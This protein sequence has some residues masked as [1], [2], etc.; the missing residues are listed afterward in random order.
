MVLVGAAVAA[1]GLTYYQALKHLP[2]SLAIV[3]LFQ[4]SWMLPVLG[5]IASRR[6]PTTQQWAALAAILIG[7]AA[8]AHA[9]R[10]AGFSAIGLMLGL[11]AG[12]AYAMTLF[13]QDRFGDD[14]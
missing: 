13:W 11:A 3:L 4:F 8:A 5:W 6:A 9:G 12:L 10:L 7:S 14:T 2:A 1:T